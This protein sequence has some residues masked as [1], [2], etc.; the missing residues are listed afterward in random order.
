M[1]VFLSLL[2]EFGKQVVFAIV[3]YCSLPPLAP[4]VNPVAPQ[5]GMVTNCRVYNRSVTEVLAARR[6][7]QKKTYSVA[8]TLHITIYFY[9]S[10]WLENPESNSKNLLKTK[11][12]IWQDLREKLGFVAFNVPVFVLDILICYILQIWNYWLKF[13]FHSFD[14]EMTARFGEEGLSIT[15]IHLL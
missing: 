12:I 2:L 13:L 7:V 15:K 9:K 14:M 8:Y 10:L 1:C 3:T 5:A 6:L 4:L 11:N